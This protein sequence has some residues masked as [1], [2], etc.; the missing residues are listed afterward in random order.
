MTCSGDSPRAEVG[1]LNVSA[2]TEFE[3]RLLAFI[4]RTLLPDADLPIDRETY[5]FADS[6]I[7]SMRILDLVAF[8]ENWL[9]AEIG[10]DDVTMDHFRSAS[11]I[12]EYFA[13]CA[14]TVSAVP[15]RKNR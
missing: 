14:N 13:P 7:N 11:A 2:Q 9:G 15:R 10:L 3:A 8:V 4:R 1:Q 6:L 12:A 5:L